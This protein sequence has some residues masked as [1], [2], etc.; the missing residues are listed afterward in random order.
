MCSETAQLAEYFNEHPRITTRLSTPPTGNH[1]CF[2]GAGVASW[3]I[4]VLGVDLLGGR[5]F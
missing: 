1:G 5:A 2:S 3:V 4:V